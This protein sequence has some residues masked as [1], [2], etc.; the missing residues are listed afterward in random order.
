MI[1]ITETSDETAREILSGNRFAHLALSLNDEPYVVPIHYVFDGESVFFYTTEGKKTGILSENPLVCLQTESVIN[2]EDWSSVIVNGRAVY[3]DG[4][5]REA[6]VELLLKSNPHL[7]PALALK[8][9]DQWV[10]QNV[11]AVYKIEIR[12]ISGRKTVAKRVAD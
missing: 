12:S 6:A 3:L 9:M 11:E 10:R 4:D 2:A 1:E 5:E 8:W 7:T